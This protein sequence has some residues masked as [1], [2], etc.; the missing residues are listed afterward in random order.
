MKYLSIILA[1]MG[2]GVT[3]CSTLETPDAKIT[4]HE[5]YV[6]TSSGLVEADQLEAG[7]YAQNQ[8]VEAGTYTRA[9][10]Q[11]K[12]IGPIPESA[13]IQ[14]GQQPSQAEM[15]LNAA[16]GLANSIPGGQPFGLALLGLSAIAKIWRD[17]RTIKDYTAVAR[18]LASARDTSLDVVATLPDREQAQKIENAINEGTEHFAKQL[19]NARAILDALLTET[20]TPTKK[21]L[22]G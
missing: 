15:S 17:R 16:A 2:L 8:V 21:P 10:L 12:A 5:T 14:A 6:A 13:T 20:A 3:A 1:V 19:G 22:H 18:T 4:L 7:T 11:Q 9:E